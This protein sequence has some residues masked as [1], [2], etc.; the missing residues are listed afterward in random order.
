[1]YQ[2][3]ENYQSKVYQAS[4]RHLLEIYI[5]DTKISSKYIL[6]CNLTNTLFSND[7]FCLGGVTSQAVELKLYKTAIP[8]TIQSIYIQTGIGEETI[9][10]GYFNIEEISKEDDYT[11][12]LKLLDNMIKF[13]QNYDGSHL[14]YPCT[15]MEVLQDICSKAGVDLGVTSFLNMDNVVSVYD[16]TLSS[17]TYI[18]YI[19]EQAGGFASIGRDGKLYIKTIGQDKAELPLK[20]FQNFKWGEKFTL[21]RVKYE[22]GVQLFEKGNELGNTLY[23]NQNNLYIT[24]QEQIDNIYEKLSGL[25]LY[26]FEGSSIIDPALDIG[27]III[28]EGKYIIYQGSSH[29]IGKFKADI[30][31][32]IQCKEKEETMIRT[33]SQSV[34]NRRVQSQIDQEAQ[35]ITLLTEKTEQADL[36]IDTISHSIAELNE[37]IDGITMTVGETVSKLNNDYLTAEQIEAENNTIKEGLDIIKQQQSKMELTSEGL[38]VQI[39]SIWTEGVENVKNT[40]VRIDQDG[41]KVS[42]GE[43]FSSLLNDTRSVFKI[44]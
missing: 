9:P 11:V 15:L 21:T 23:I 19:A 40:L 36:S 8:D 5:N 24:N 22:D 34:I 39:D 7:E 10:I 14:N 30:S 13:E 1:M 25:E 4:T 32:K 6:D 16:N 37:E 38:Q 31:S 26:S 17:R 44:I 35:K 2:T 20:Y 42:K 3:S 29:Y 12:T 27:D 33:P 43:E 28:V 41:I 18:S